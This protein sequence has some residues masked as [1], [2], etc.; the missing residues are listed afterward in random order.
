MALVQ[1]GGAPPAPPAAD[2]SFV[3]A[4]RPRSWLPCS[5][6]GSH[7]LSNGVA[8]RPGPEEEIDLLRKAGCSA[9]LQMVQSPPQPE[10]SDFQADQVLLDASRN[11]V[12]K[13]QLSR[14]S[15]VLHVYDLSEGLQKANEL[16]LYALAVGGAFHVGVESYGCEWS[17]GCRGVKAS[18]PRTAAGH[19]YHC[20]LHLG[21]TSHGEHSFAVLMHSMCQA[22][23]GA[24]Y[25][26]LGHN[27]CS[28]A[29]ELCDRLGVGP[30][31]AWVNRI[32]RLLHM[33][34]EAGRGVIA[35]GRRASEVIV[36]EALAATAAVWDEAMAAS[37]AMRRGAAVA[38]QMLAQQVCNHAAIEASA[39][40]SGDLAGAAFAALCRTVAERLLQEER[41]LRKLPQYRRRDASKERCISPLPIKV[42]DKEECREACAMTPMR[43]TEWRRP[44]A[45]QPVYHHGVVRASHRV[46]RQAPQLRVGAVA[47][48]TCMGVPLRLPLA[49]PSAPPAPL[50]PPRLAVA[51]VVSNPSMNV[52]PQQ[53]RTRTA[54]F[55]RR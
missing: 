21:T 12:D 4:Q 13:A 1:N 50:T 16:L 11:P 44:A 41:I 37:Q 55:Q 6:S 7:A 5:E 22:W 18:V 23:R 25:H 38:T 3:A 45:V 32:A 27:C 29:A 28:F 30:M 2:C 9:V 35:A 51:R 24:D 42:E 52:P 34:Q 10:E 19:V 43:R 54:V 15:V 46:Q 49:A 33:S 47:K 40:A 53:P 48:P 26:V 20:S 14:S 36:S 17:Y 8:A 39:M 31:P